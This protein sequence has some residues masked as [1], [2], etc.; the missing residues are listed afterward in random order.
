M[1]A[2]ALGTHAT[3][4]AAQPH[5]RRARWHAAATAFVTLLAA[6]G[7]AAQRA[8]ILAAHAAHTAR[9][10]HAAHATRTAAAAAAACE[11]A[12]AAVASFASAHTDRFSS[13]GSKHRHTDA[14]RI[15]RRGRL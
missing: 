5:T 15:R 6:T 8:A 10:T 2:V 7:T 9:T 13:S 14:D 4:T 12:S 3:V 1:A 11:A